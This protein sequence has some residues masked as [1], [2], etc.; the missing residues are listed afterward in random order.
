MEHRER[1][2]SELY[3]QGLRF[4]A[5][6]REG[7]RE[8]ERERERRDRER[9]RRQ[10]KRELIDFTELEYSWIYFFRKKPSLTICPC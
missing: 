10:G 5:I 4:L 9:E 7:G 1:E 2:N 3:Y 8:R 6:A